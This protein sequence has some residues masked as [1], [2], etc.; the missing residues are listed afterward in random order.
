MTAVTS[1]PLG[2]ARNP[3]RSTKALAT[4][5]VALLIGAL[6]GVAFTIVSVGFTTVPDDHP[7]KTAADYWYTGLG[8]PLVI[9]GLALVQSMRALNAGQDGRRGRWGAALF[10]IPMPIFAA[11]FIQALA[12]GHT[13]SWGPTYLLC[14]LVSDIGLGLLVSG[15]W[16]VG[17]LSRWQLALWWIGWFVGGAFALGPA[18]LLLTAAYV[19]LSVALTRATR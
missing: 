15:S 13:S 16:R 17:L 7:F 2:Y 1:T 5:L 14:V 8:L 10:S 9:S 4:A 18:A 3:A 19:V 11:M 12:Q 6:W